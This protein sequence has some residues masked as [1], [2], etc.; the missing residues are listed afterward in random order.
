MAYDWDY[1]KKTTLWSYEE[2]V[3]KL[4]SVLAY[5]LIRQAYNHSMP[6]AADYACRLFPGQEHSAALPAA[7]SRLEAA[8][9]RDWAGFLGRVATREACI[10][11]VEQNGIP[12]EEVIDTLKYLLRW[13]FP[14]YTATREL[15]DHDNGMEMAAYEALKA[16]RLVC[17]FDLLERGRTLSDRQCLAEQLG[18]PL[19]FT[20]AIV[21]RADIARL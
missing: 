17:S 20:H 1:V 2:L 10:E 13:A 6:Q 3:R 7:F 16:H 8:G 18:L 21:N 11:F 5:P 19:E 4:N 14:F 15:L 12:F 9:V